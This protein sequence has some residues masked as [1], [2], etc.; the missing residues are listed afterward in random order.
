MNATV[1]RLDVD[2]KEELERFEQAKYE[3]LR[4]CLIYAVI[5]LVLLLPTSPYFIIFLN[6][7]NRIRLHFC[8]FKMRKVNALV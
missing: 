2:N 1:N 4:I 7:M 3:I 8:A 5:C 6:N